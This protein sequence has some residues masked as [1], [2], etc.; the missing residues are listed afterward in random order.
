MA[1]RAGI[2][3]TG[4]EVIG[5]IRADRN[6]PW[7]AS[8]LREVGVEPVEIAIVGDRPAD[9]ERALHCLRE[10]GVELIVTSGGLGPTDDDLTAS[11]VGRF[12][13]RPLRRDAELEERIGRIVAAIA[14]R[15]PN[16]SAAALATG[17]RKQATVPEGATVLDPVGTA[18]G[19]IVPPAAGERPLVLV[20]PGPPREL[21]PMFKAAL[22]KEPLA[23]LLAKARPRELG[24]VRLFGIPESELTATIRAAEQA[25]VS[26][27]GLEITTCLHRGELEVTTAYPPELADRYKAF[28]AYL[29][30]RHRREVFSTDGRTIDELL[31][32]LLVER[33][34][35]V[36]T[37]ESCTGGLLAG[38]LTDLPGSSRYF[39]GGVVAYANEVK[40][41]VAGVSGRTLAAHG[42]V[43]EEVARELAQRATAVLEATVGVGITGIA[44]PGGGT[45]QKP[46]GLVHLA[47][48]RADLGVTIAHR[49]EL[50]GGREAI[51]ERAV[52]IAMHLIR[53]AALQG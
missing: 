53:R 48:H 51:R 45:A 12:Q 17:T 3:V 26:L 35:T 40:E 25:G 43:S 46:V 6:G 27:A 36:A 38:R 44:G 18:P 16:A 24:V 42:A 4:T 47:A 7:L 52:T 29:S 22:G 34:L 33:G 31:A 30:N 20:L 1:L 32:A 39:R 50:L 8:R 37:A 11:V 41:R 15:F 13:G 5:G 2:V 21:Q 49:V 19:L 23:G 10:A 14:R 9:L 28:V